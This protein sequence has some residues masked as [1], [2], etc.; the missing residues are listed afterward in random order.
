ML[1]L[2]FHLGEDP[3]VLEASRIIEVLPLVRIK[4]MPGAG[5]SGIGVINHRGAP[6]PVIDLSALILGR[7][8]RKLLSTRIVLIR[9]GGDDQ[10]G[11]WLGLT[12]EQ[13]T[14][15]LRRDPAGFVAPGLTGGGAP[16]LGPVLADARGLIHW[17]DPDKVL[18][19]VLGGASAPEMAGSA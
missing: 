12:L 2:L 3:Y 19:H 6:V 15:T 4:A 8:A 14:E 9:G 17:I 7:P 11:Q 18:A 5:R 13:A 1:F 16:Y 10:A